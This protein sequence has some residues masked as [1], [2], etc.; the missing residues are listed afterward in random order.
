MLRDDRLA[1]DLAQMAGLLE[2]ITGE[3]LGRRQP[4]DGSEDIGL[5]DALD[6]VGRIGE[7]DELERQFAAAL[8]DDAAFAQDV[9]EVGG[10]CN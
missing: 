8:A 2:A 7:Y 6:L 1:W 5:G 4:F 3:Q 10:R 9:H